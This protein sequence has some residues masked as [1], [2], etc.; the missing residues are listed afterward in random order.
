MLCDYKKNKVLCVFEKISRV[1]WYAKK[2]KC[3]IMYVQ[4]HLCKN[5]KEKCS[6]LV[7]P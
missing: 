5:E 3:R 6:V 4:F 2:A 1:Y 7:W